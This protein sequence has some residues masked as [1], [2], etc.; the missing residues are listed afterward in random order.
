MKRVWSVI[1]LVAVLFWASSC[2]GYAGDEDYAAFTCDGEM[3]LTHTR[4]TGAVMFSC[5]LS[6]ED[7]QTF[8]RIWNEGDWVAELIECMPDYRLTWDGNLIYYRTCCGIY[9]MHTDEGTLALYPS[10]ADKAEAASI[11]QRY[12]DVYDP[13]EDDQPER[14]TIQ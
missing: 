11:V 8:L 1:M 7:E 9:T 5:A 6:E 10:D 14:G 3:M 4:P 12:A 2:D 13:I